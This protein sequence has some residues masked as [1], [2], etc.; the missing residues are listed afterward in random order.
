[1]QLVNQATNGTNKIKGIL[2]HQGENDSAKTK[3]RY[4]NQL[5]TM[6]NSLQNDLTFEKIMIAIVSTSESGYGGGNTD[7]PQQ[8]QYQIIDDLD[9]AVQ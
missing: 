7:G 5:N 1:L 4:Y 3:D 6:I 2:W 8:A 9:R